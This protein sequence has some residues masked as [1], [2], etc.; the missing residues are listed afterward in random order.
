[1]T[2]Q[3]PRHSVSVAAVVV[4]DEGRVL[5]IKRRDNDKWEPPGGVLELYEPILQGLVREVR[6]ETGLHVEP[7]PLSGVYKNVERGIVALVFRCAPISGAIS[8]TP[9]TQE[10]TWLA[11]HQITEHMDEAYAIRF[12]D[13]L[14]EGPPNVRTHDGVNLIPDEDSGS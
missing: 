14:H 10:S 9:E 2:A 13:A 4:N 5:A 7:G 1:M 12:L 8:A 11:P 3:T 6:E